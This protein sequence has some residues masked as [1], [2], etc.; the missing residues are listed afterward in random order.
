MTQL[1]AVIF[2][3][4]L[5]PAPPLAESGASTLPETNNSTV[6]VAGPPSRVTWPQ[7][8]RLFIFSHLSFQDMW[9]ETHAL[10]LP[11]S[12]ATLD[13]PVLSQG[14]GPRRGGDKGVP[15]QS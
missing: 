11:A 6:K 5:P 9:C 14:E 8:Q 15:G 12:Q 13:S 2:T 7:D 10:S 4:Q 3:S 1:K